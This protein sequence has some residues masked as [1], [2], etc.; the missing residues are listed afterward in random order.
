MF[1]LPTLAFGKE[2]ILPSGLQ[3][4]IPDS[5]ISYYEKEWKLFT[6]PSGI[7]WWAETIVHIPKAQ[8]SELT[9]EEQ[10]KLVII[11]WAT[12]YGVSSDYMI[13]LARCESNFN[14]EAHNPR[15]P[16]GGAKGLFQYLSPTWNLWQKE[17]GIKGN[18]YDWRAQVEM[19]SWALSKGRQKSWFNCDKY[20][21]FN[22]WDKK[23]WE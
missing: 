4:E 1:F 18:I 10:I 16:A 19:V 15:D 22:T 12:E 7:T 6:L 2:F 8:A 14:V 20:I 21:R 17:S 9:L 3:I 13:R 23:L 11:K 5:E